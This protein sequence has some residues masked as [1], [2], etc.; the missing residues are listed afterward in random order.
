MPTNRKKINHYRRI[1]GQTNINKEAFHYQFKQAY[2]DFLGDRDTREIIGNA[3]KKLNYKG[4]VAQQKTDTTDD[5]TGGAPDIG[6][7]VAPHHRKE[8]EIVP[9]LLM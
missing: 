1:L 4:R 6:S 5:P 8:K 2:G 9:G 3:D 7:T